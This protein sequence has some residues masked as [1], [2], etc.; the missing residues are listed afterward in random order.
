MSGSTFL[1]YLKN[2]EE[3]N[4]TF[5]SGV[6]QVNGIFDGVKRHEWR[7]S[8]RPDDC[9]GVKSQ[10]YFETREILPLE[11]DNGK[12]DVEEMESR[13]IQ[14]I[15]PVDV[16]ERIVLDGGL[17]LCTPIRTFQ[18]GGEVIKWLPFGPTSKFFIPSVTSD[19]LINDEDEL[20]EAES[21]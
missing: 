14:V 19:Y 8:R 12:E 6:V 9:G 4:A 21:K 13:T 17:Y 2:N 7:A 11:I 20:Y 18:F 3:G 1:G 15:L 16:I 10:D 5:L